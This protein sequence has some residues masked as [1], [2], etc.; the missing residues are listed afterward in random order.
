MARI[1]MHI[2]KAKLPFYPPSEV[3]CELQNEV[4]TEHNISLGP[5]RKKHG[6]LGKVELEISH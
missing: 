3:K 4:S 5:F 2:F 1:K 6:S